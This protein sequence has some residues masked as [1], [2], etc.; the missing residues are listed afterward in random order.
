MFLSLPDLGDGY[1]ACTCA[2]IPYI[3]PGG[4]WAWI[5]GAYQFWGT[6]MWGSQSWLQPLFRRLHCSER[7]LCFSRTS[8]ISGSIAEPPRKAAAAMIGC[9]TS[10]SPKTDKHP[11]ITAHSE[12]GVPWAWGD[13]LDYRDGDKPLDDPLRAEDDT[14]ESPK[15]VQLTA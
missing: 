1:A 6:A 4:N 15:V 12:N 13:V 2:S 7:N 9:P 8:C 5:T 3:P 10:Q 11:W 14:G